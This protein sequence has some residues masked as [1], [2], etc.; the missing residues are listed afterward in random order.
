[1]RTLLLVWLVSVWAALPGLAQRMGTAAA[2]P[3]GGEPPVSG[4]AVSPWKQRLDS[5]FQAVDRTPV[6]TGLLSDYGFSFLNPDNYTGAALLDSNYVDI[7]SWRLLYAA[8][9]TSKFTGNATLPG[10]RSAVNPALAP[11][12]DGVVKMA[13]LLARY[14]RLRDD[15]V[16]QGLMSV[17]NGR[18]YDV[19]GRSQSPY[20]TRTLAAVAPNEAGAPLGPVVFEFNIARVYRNAAPNVVGI[21]MDADD[22]QGYRGVYYAHP[23]MQRFTANYTTSGTKTLRYR[24]TCGDGTILVGQSFFEVREQEVAR[25]DTV[26]PAV[27]QPT[28]ALFTDQRTFTEPVSPFSTY[29]ATGRVTVA[30]S[31]FNPTAT[32]T[33]RILKPLIVIEGYDP[34]R[35]LTLNSPDR[36]YNWNTFA[37]RRVF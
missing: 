26:V 24:L 37:N 34:W 32:T 3:G 9:E 22:G 27:T 5:L 12:P 33:R 19:P 2:A 18:F 15:A 36:N 31:R 16:A 4:V 35:I 17:S 23:G 7:N 21:D 10:L 30:L 6:S 13:V 1:M 29:A 28:S 14:E 20:Q 11:S 25:Y 8:L